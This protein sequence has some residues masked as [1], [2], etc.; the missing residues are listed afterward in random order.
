VV[1]ASDSAS[2]V[3]MVRSLIENLLFI[4]YE[5][6]AV[7]FVAADFKASFGASCLLPH[8]GRITAA[9]NNSAAADKPHF[10]FIIFLLS[11]VKKISPPY[12][13]LFVKIKKHFFIIV[14]V[15]IYYPC[16]L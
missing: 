14:I 16:G 10:L 7:A 5:D 4:S 15:F 11:H 9:V 6:I 13:K 2:A 3:S 8:P 12:D 1:I